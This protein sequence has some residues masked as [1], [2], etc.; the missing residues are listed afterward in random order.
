MED[1]IIKADWI[2]RWT[3]LPDNLEDFRQSWDLTF[4]YE[5][6]LVVGQVWARSGA[7]FY[8]IEYKMT[9]EAKRKALLGSLKK[10]EGICNGC[11]EP[12]EGLDSDS[13]CD[14]YNDNNDDCTPCPLFKTGYGCLSQNSPYGIFAHHVGTMP[15]TKTHHN[16][17]KYA[18]RMYEIICDLCIANGIDVDAKGFERGI[19]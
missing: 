19:K 5:E 15:R 9:D 12:Y 6:S 13:L 10:W 17:I 8:L 1:G 7:D 11:I 2:K 18:E 16:W 4:D 14:E 3:V